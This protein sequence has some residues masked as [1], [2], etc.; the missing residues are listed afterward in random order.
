MKQWT[1]G[2]F[3]LLT[4]GTLAAAEVD[5]AYLPLTLTW[6]SKSGKPFLHLHGLYGESAWGVKPVTAVP[7]SNRGLE[8]RFQLEPGGNGTVEQEMT[9]P[10]NVTQIVLWGHPLD[11]ARPGNAMVGQITLAQTDHHFLFWH[12]TAQR[13]TLTY[14][15]SYPDGSGS[16]IPFTLNVWIQEQRAS[17]PPVMQTL[18]PVKGILTRTH[19]RFELQT[20][21]LPKPSTTTSCVLTLIVSGNCLSETLQFRSLVTKYVG[22]AT[23]TIPLTDL[24][25]NKGKH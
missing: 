6:G 8:L 15:F 4:A 2:L 11:I 21:A 9:L 10:P 7:S 22:L 14:V 12:W 23:L 3:F 18:P 20:L 16:E 19:G 1:I 5:P 25:P 13:S 24:R 17:D